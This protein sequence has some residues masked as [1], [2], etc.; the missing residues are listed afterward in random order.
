MT[1]NQKKWLLAALVTL[2]GIIVYT[3]TMSPTVSF[4][5][6]GEYIS[7][8]SI[9]GIGH[10]PGAPTHNL[11]ARLAILS[12]VWFRDV[13]ARVNWISAL[14]A[15]FTAGC[16][17]LSVERG[18]YL[19]QKGENREKYAWVRLF[20][21][22]IGG[23][24]TVFNDTF[25]FSAIEAEMY[26]S[27]ALVNFICI[28]LMLYW[29]DLRKTPWGDRILAFIVYLS[30]LGTGF[31]LS[32]VMF[33]PIFAIFIVA[34]DEEKRKNWALY[35]V[36]VLIMSV[37]FMPGRFPFIT[38]VLT[39][40]M[41]LLW[42]FPIGGTRKQYK[43]AFM[44][45]FMAL[46]G[47]SILVYIPI[48]ASLRPIVN[49]GEAMIRPQVDP[50]NPATWENFKKPRSLFYALD[51][52][53]WT[54]MQEVIERKQYVSDNMLVRAM[55][56]RG[57]VANQLLVHQNMGFGGY[58]TSQYLP[59]KVDFPVKRFGIRIPSQVE[60]LGVSYAPDEANNY[61]AITPGAFNKRI[62]SL[63]LLLL[64]HV[65]I[66]YV[67]K[68]GWKQN[69]QA[70]LLL[71]GLYVFAS[72]GILWYINFADGT[73]ADYSEHK[74]YVEQSRNHP[75]QELKQPDPVH[76][77]VRIRDYFWT[78]GFVMVA[79]LYG[80]A[81]AMMAQNLK[82]RLDEGTGGRQARPK[83]LAFMVLVSCTPA[84][85]CFSNW[86][87]K[88]RSNNWVAFDY[89]Y[90]LLMSCD[91]NAILFTNGDNDTFPLW[92]LQ[93]AYGIRPDVR[94]VNL[95]LLNTDWYIRQ[96]RDIDPKVPIVFTDAE[97]ASLQPT[98][99]EDS[100]PGMIKVGNYV[101][102]KESKQQRP[103]YRVQDIM[104]LHIV[105]VNAHLA[106]PKPINFAATVGDD[107][108]L[109]LE[110]YVQMRGLVYVLKPTQVQDRVDVSGTRNLFEKVYKFRGLGKNRTWLDEDSE[111]LITNY[112][113][114]AV[115]V[116]MEDV[117][118]IKAMQDSIQKAKA[119]DAPAA[120]KARAAQLPA[121]ISRKVQSGMQ[122]M[123]KVRD[124][125]P[126]E[127]R[128]PYY[129]SQYYT[130]IGMLGQAEATLQA[131]RRI[132]P[133]EALLVRGLCDLYLRAG[134]AK[135][136]MSLYDSASKNRYMKDDPRLLEGEA[137]TLAE[138][139]KFEEALALVDRLSAGNQGDQRL[140][141]LRQMIQSRLEAARRPASGP[142]IGGL[143]G[144][145]GQAA[146]AAAPAAQAPAAT[147]EQ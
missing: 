93:Y 39:A 137:M 133:N 114:I 116:A 141:M 31:T 68:Y 35:A 61:K 142:S 12:F 13:G 101:V 28:T 54:T 132:I 69:K 20:G 95:S 74:E 139:G 56:R 30:F 87:E 112:S 127:W 135:K 52:A 71:T 111:R 122:L 48:R 86:K 105:D 27:A 119:P 77:E 62:L 79:L 102:V 121:E 46:L 65:P 1:Y 53:N 104:T 19:F 4:W 118:A 90:N 24:L 85:A 124:L 29:V 49:E 99:N 128:T 58:M 38:L 22:V 17:F 60:A 23:L 134:Q 144:L 10:P 81:A 120:L 67:A 113:S 66:Y 63:L 8:G 57:Q 97:I 5:D 131:A 140:A 83:F 33:V 2:V 78:P 109:G 125:N 82:Q 64:A 37:V 47:W 145:S 25:W 136:A 41:A 110:P 96:M 43:L 130:E 3:L 18:I 6:C 129:I 100:K 115:Q 92:A 147:Q 107:N 55:Y 138:I 11:L 14:S 70:T 75:D 32:S 143:P 89:S 108:F 80:M 42:A 59:F 9:L 103:Y 123:N 117:P 36:G 76:M 126:D 84:L 15:A 72:F 94:L 7:A 16:V 45:S 98:G 106:H 73:K 34:V 91:K 88:D 146:P 44:L 40:A 51:P 50:Q 21:G 26:C